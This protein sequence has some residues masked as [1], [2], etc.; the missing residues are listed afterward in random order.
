MIGK[1][2]KTCLRKLLFVNEQFSVV[3]QRRQRDSA[4][5]Q[6]S[7]S[8]LTV[9]TSSI[10]SR[11]AWYR[12]EVA[13][14]APPTRAAEAHTRQLEQ[15]RPTHTPTRAAEA[16]THANSSGRGPHTRQLEQQRLTHTPTRAAEAH[17]RQ[18]ER[19][20]STHTE[21][22]PSLLTAYRS[23]SHAD[24]TSWSSHS[25]QCVNSADGAL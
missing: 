9:Q 11:L 13:S 19:Q 14:P 17:T 21:R 6:S 5:A 25:V 8:S 16:H 24:H 1:A 22:L 20:R 4:S 23:S 3:Q 7:H 18:L 15:Q 12:S 10:H 2:I